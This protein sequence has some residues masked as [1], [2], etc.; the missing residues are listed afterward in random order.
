MI[1][2]VINAICTAETV[3]DFFLESIVLIFFKVKA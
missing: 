2:D 1:I 3:Y